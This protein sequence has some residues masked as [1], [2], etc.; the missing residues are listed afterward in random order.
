MGV[1]GESVG[2]RHSFDRCQPPTTLSS[3]RTS[4][5]KSRVPQVPILGPGIPQISMDPRRCSCCVCSSAK[6]TPTSFASLGHPPP[7]QPCSAFPLSNP[8]SIDE[9][10]T[11]IDSHRSDADPHPFPER[12]RSL[13]LPV[14]ARRTPFG[15]R[16][17]SNILREVS[18]GR[19]SRSSLSWPEQGRGA[20]NRFPENA[21][22]RR[23]ESRTRC[24][25]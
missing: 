12:L 18:Y 11:Q 22:S 20:V 21:E 14:I 13:A 10:C 24:N 7:H 15:T 2:T 9:Q 6:K 5:Q 23:E 8:P 25:P 19:K 1:P 16:A 3:L 4:S 17:A